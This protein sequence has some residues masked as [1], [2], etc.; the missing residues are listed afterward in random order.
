MDTSL[1]GWIFNTH[2]TIKSPITVLSVLFLL[3]AGSFVEIAPRKSLEFLDTSFGSLLFFVTPLAVSMV[4][5]W[6]TGLLTAVISL[7]IV[8]RLQRHEL[9]EGFFSIK[10]NASSMTELIPNPKRW[11]VEKILGETPIA[12]SSDR[13]SSS[14]MKDIDT[15]T[16]SSSSMSSSGTSDSSHSSK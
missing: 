13:V 12:I 5:D 1:K 10:D 11:F 8:A 7:I 15:R 3:I 14:E 2:T 4:L 16:S 6:P 9:S